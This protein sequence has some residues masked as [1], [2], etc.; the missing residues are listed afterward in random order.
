[1]SE[2]TLKAYRS[3]LLHLVDWLLEQDISLLNVTLDVLE[4]YLEARNKAGASQRTQ[5][6]A[7]SSMRRFYRYAVR[8]C[9][10]AED[11]TALLE[12]PKLGMSL[13]KTLSEQEVERLLGAP[14]T[15]SPEG[16]RDRAMMEL[17]YA[18]GLRVSELVGLQQ[19]Q[20]NLNFGVVRV[21]GKGGK[22]RLVP[23]GEEAMD[24][25][26][27]Y[28]QTARGQLLKAHGLVD[29]VF[30][31]RRGGG[32]T[33]QTFWHAIKR[34]AQ[35][36]GIHKHLSPHTLRHAFATHLVN[37]GADLRV[38]QMLLGHSDISTTQIYTHVAQTRLQALHARHHPRG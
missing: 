9:L 8:E 34:H 37:H 36:A 13:P 15:V 22:E 19:D 11:P 17:L 14:D 21:V 25:L 27:R 28:M 23:L 30:V 18:T 32:M 38:V 33:R 16:L 35:T 6:R 5:A 12:S 2:N 3:D 29:A 1:M 4:G 7:L 26:Q 10:M 20:L 31:T 24:W